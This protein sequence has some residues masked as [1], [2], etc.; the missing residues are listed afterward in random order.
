[1]LKYLG[2]FF[3]K[4]QIGLIQ[5]LEQGHFVALLT[6]PIILVPTLLLVLYLK[7]VFFVALNLS[8][9][10]GDALVRGITFV[11][12]VWSGRYLQHRLTVCGAKISLLGLG[13]F[14]LATL[15]MEFC[16]HL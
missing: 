10:I 16:L 4:S 15:L 7:D 11:A 9:G 1:M 5:I 12:M 3:L 13:I 8:G 14:A 6:V 2:E